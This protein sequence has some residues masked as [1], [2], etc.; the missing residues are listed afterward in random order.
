MTKNAFVAVVTGGSS[1]VGRA[2]ASYFAASGYDVAIIARG[3]QGVAEATEDLKRYGGRVLGICAD[4]ADPQQVSNAAQRIEEELGPMSVWVNC[5]MTTVLAPV[6]DISFDE[7]RRVTEVTYLGAVNGTRSAL[8]YMQLRDSGTIIQVGSAL[9]WRSIPLQSAYCG[10]KAAIRA[11]TDSLRCELLHQKSGV[12]VSMVQL[13]AINT[14]QFNWARNKFHHRMQP[15]EPIYQP[16]VAAKAIYDAAV[17]RRPP[18]EVWLG[19]NT[20]MSIVGN[21]FFPGLLD[22]YVTKTWEGQLTDEAEPT[23]RPDYLFQPLENGHQAHGRFDS[24]A[25]NKAIAVDSRVMGVAAVAVAGLLV[26]ALFRRR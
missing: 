5:A 6:E 20:V 24:H 21:M 9:A 16:E 12:R 25:K 3:E 10:A 18:R 11:F 13:P 4:V 7:F 23:Q 8:R 22:R 14:T 26:K 17:A 15:I 1:G 2:T 19:K